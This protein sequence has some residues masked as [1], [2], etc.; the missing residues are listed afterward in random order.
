[1]LAIFRLLI[2]LFLVITL[3]SCR[4]TISQNIPV[5]LRENAQLSVAISEV[6]PPTAIQQLHSFVEIYQPQISIVTPKQDEV[7][8]DDT[9]TVNLQ[10]KDLPIFKDP[11]LSLGSHLHVI[12]DNHPYQDIY[13]LNQPLTLSDLPP[14]THTLRVFAELPWYESFKNEGAYAQT[15]FHIFTKTDDNNP[16]ISQPLLTYSR[17]WGVYGAEPILLDFYLTNAPLRMVSKSNPN[18]ANSD[19]RIRCTINGESFVFDRWQPAYLKGFKPG[20]NWVKLEFL[21]NQGNPV[22]N[23]FNTTVGLL[24][25]DPKAKDSLSEITRGK[26]SPEEARRIVDPNY[27]AK[28][29]EPTPETQLE[30]PIKAKPEETPTLEPK[31]ETI[32]QATPTPEPKA[33]KRPETKPGGFFNR[34]KRPVSE[35]TPSDSPTPPQPESKIIPEIKPTPIPDIAPIPEVTPQINPQQKIEPSLIPEIKESKQSETAPVK[36]APNPEEPELERYFNPSQIPNTGSAILGN[37]SKT[38]LTKIDVPSDK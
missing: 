12:L 5:S 35:P 27:T 10:V 2:G 6:S 23:V 30:E 14:G 36:I 8:Q 24:T 9:V 34:F 7:L 29:P 4:E 22:K 25:Y 17:P 38:K 19:W 28:I 13:D 33:E 21:D 20:K 31:A 3:T 16:D 37:N 11:D 18:N 15:T 26:L 32:P 1:M